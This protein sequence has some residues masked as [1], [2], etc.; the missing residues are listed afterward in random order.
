ML[1]RNSGPQER[2]SF[3]T[4][5]DCIVPEGRR[6]FPSG[7]QIVAAPGANAAEKRQLLW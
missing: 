4:K 6:P 7:G 1:R 2:I 3:V 5:V